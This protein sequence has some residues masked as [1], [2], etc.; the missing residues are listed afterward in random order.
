MERRV[1]ERFDF[2]RR[3]VSGVKKPISVIASWPNN[4]SE[5][6]RGSPKLCRILAQ[7]QPVLDFSKSS[8]ASSLDLPKRTRPAGYAANISS[9]EWGTFVNEEGL[10]FRYPSRYYIT[11]AAESLKCFLNAQHM[12]FHVFEVQCAGLEMHWRS[13]L[14]KVLETR[15]PVYGCMSVYTGKE[16]FEI[17]HF[18]IPVIKDNRIVELRGWF[19][20]AYNGSLPKVYWGGVRSVRR[21]E[22]SRIVELPSRVLE[23]FSRLAI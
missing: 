10:E 15:R 4:S 11:C 23:T 3:A 1:S 16:E 8:G 18:A 7:S 14:A 19:Y 22:R 13:D 2:L 17:E 21:F 5:V 12:P 20:E 6:P 9:F